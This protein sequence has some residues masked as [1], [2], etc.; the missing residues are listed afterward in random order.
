M[1]TRGN[2]S[3]FS[4]L[5]L[6]GKIFARKSCASV[7]LE[8]TDNLHLGGEVNTGP[9]WQQDLSRSILFYFTTV[10]SHWEFSYGKFGRFSRGKPDVTESRYPTY[11][12]CWV[13]QYFHN[14]LNLA[15][16]TGSL[17]CTHILM[18]AIAHGDVQTP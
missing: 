7:H 8:H 14:P 9:L 17:T 11:S 13:F 16:T 6:V 4:L 18:H 1:L 5:P 15:W 12:V 10:L 2:C 3:D